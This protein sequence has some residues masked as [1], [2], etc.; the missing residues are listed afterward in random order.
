MPD[1]SPAWIALIGTVFGGAGLKFTE[2]WLNRQTKEADQGTKIRDELR[3]QIEGLKIDADKLQVQ[4]DKTEAELDEWK[5]KY[6]ALVAEF[7]AKQIEVMTLL[8]TAK[9]AHDEALTDKSPE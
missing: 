8:A 6:W 9:T 2:T 5:H 4:I 1:I 7:N 3:I